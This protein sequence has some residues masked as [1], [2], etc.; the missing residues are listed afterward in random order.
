MGRWPNPNN[1][2]KEREPW[3]CVYTQNDSSHGDGVGYV[4]DTEVPIPKMQMEERRDA[5]ARVGAST[6]GSGTLTDQRRWHD[7][8][9]L[10]VV[11]ISR[12]HHRIL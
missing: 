4:R 6:D 10:L 1:K 8:P 3:K 7:L 2:K 9:F 11:I 5:A 12:P